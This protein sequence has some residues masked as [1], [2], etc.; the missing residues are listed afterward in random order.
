MWYYILIIKTFKFFIVVEDFLLC[1]NDCRK[2]SSLYVLLQI[3]L[4]IS[5]P[6]KITYPKRLISRAQIFP[7]FIKKHTKCS[8]RCLH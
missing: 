6:I 2:Y 7:P 5:L 4:Y 8:Q 1:Y 3:L